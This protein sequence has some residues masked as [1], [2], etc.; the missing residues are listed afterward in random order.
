MFRLPRAS[1]M[2]AFGLSLSFTFTTAGATVPDPSTH[3][4]VPGDYNHDGLIDALFQPLDTSGG[5]AVVLQDSTGQLSIVSQ[6]WNTGY[7]GIDW[8]ASDTKLTAGDLNGDGYD[9]I[10]L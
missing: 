2:L 6:S 10:V 8:A 1:S 7:L 5:G 4:L 9:D 3:L